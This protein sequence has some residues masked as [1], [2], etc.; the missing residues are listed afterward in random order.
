MCRNYKCEKN[1]YIVTSHCNSNEEHYRW[2][3]IEVEDGVG[4]MKTKTENL[5]LEGNR[6]WDFILRPCD[7]NNGRQHFKGLDESGAKFQLLPKEHQRKNDA[8]CMTMLHHPLAANDDDGEMI[9]DQVCDK[10]EKTD[11]AYWTADY[12]PKIK[13]ILKKAK[14]VCR[15]KD[16]NECEGYCENDAECKGDLVCYKRGNKG[17][18]TNLESGN[19]PSGWAQVPG[20]PGYGKYGKNYCSKKAYKS[21]YSKKEIKKILD[22]S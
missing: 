2:E 15:N 19:D 16:C 22:N 10:A 21:P 6:K 7:R 9:I 17:W 11:T 13:E 12:R 1:D 18:R 14:K 8:L 20:C 5:C 4:L 3:W